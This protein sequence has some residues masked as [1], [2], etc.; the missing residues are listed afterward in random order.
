MSGTSRLGL[1]FLST[2]QAQKEFTHNE[3]LQTLDLA[4][5]AAVEE[6]ARADPPLSPAIGDCYIVGAS[7][8]GEWSGKSQ[9]V[10]GFTSG[11]WRFVGPIE[12]MTV[13]VKSEALFATFADGAWEMGVVR[14]SSVAI[15]GQQVVGPRLAA[16][17]SV[18]GGSTIDAEA[19]LTVD[20]ILD[21]LRQHGLID[22]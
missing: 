10:A 19:R 5:A 16:I 17:A 6:S 14:G 15:A 22:V 4:V 8:T 13:Y 9:S 12:G 2:G 11:G 21:A 7:A 1:P 3:A 20:A 18:A